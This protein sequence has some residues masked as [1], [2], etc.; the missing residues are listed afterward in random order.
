MVYCVFVGNHDGWGL[1]QRFVTI[2][3]ISIHVCRGQEDTIH[4]LYVGYSNISTK[5]PATTFGSNQQ[6]AMRMYGEGA[7]N[8][9]RMWHWQV[10]QICFRD[11]AQGCWTKRRKLHQKCNQVCSNTPFHIVYPRWLVS[12]DHLCRKLTSWVG[13]HL[14][15]HF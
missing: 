10:Q 14:C 13:G 2:R 8:I 6:K 7:S 11:V 9:R 1:Y 4:I 15:R 3:W 5:T 12:H